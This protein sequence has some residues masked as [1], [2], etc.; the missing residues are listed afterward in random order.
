MLQ[1]ANC[2]DMLL[3]VLSDMRDPVSLYDISNFRLK[4]R[5]L[6]PQSYS[7]SIFLCSSGKTQNSHRNQRYKT[8]LCPAPSISPGQS[9]VPRPI[10][11]Q[12]FALLITFLKNTRFSTSGTSIPVSNISTEIAICGSL[13]LD[14]K[15]HQLRS[16]HSSDNYQ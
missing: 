4:N 8:C 3:V 12:N 6:Q 10:I 13:T 16:V 14:P 2:R 1:S 9:L 15:I 5:P 11:C 7:R